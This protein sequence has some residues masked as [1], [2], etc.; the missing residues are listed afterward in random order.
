MKKN[1]QDV[2]G[3]GISLI[4]IIIMIVIY[5]LSKFGNVVNLLYFGWLNLI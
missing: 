4:G 2:L 3:C 5:L 1:K